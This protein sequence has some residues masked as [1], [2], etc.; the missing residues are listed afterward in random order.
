MCFLAH[1][2]MLVVPFIWVVKLPT[3]GWLRA[4]V[5]HLHPFQH[6]HLPSISNWNSNPTLMPS[7]VLGAFGILGPKCYLRFPGALSKHSFVF[8]T[9]S[10]FIPTIVIRSNGVVKIHLHMILVPI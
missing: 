10:T 7:K 6:H 5:P 4:R 3:F 8:L 2:S 9:K 1:L